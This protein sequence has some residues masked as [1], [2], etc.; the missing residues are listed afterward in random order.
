[1]SGGEFRLGMVCL[2]AVL[3]FCGGKNF[4][5]SYTSQECLFSLRPSGMVLIGEAESYMA[6]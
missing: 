3:V 5:C 1:M 2:D 6:A 4:R